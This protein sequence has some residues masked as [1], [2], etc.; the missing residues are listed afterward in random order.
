MYDPF[1]YVDRDTGNIQVKKIY[2]GKLNF[3]MKQELDQCNNT[4]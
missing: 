3:N 4:I 1:I 2:S